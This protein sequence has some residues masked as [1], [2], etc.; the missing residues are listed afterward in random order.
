MQWRS[1]GSAGIERTIAVDPGRIV[2]L[3]SRCNAN[4]PNFDQSPM[5]KYG[6]A[7]CIA[8]GLWSHQRRRRRT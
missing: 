2:F 8:I 7:V 3:L 1:S 6:E 4:L 5:T